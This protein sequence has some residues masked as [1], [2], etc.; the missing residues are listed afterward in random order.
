MRGLG[1]GDERMA[2]DGMRV[3]REWDEWMEGRGFEKICEGMR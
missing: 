2:R 3:S 1:A